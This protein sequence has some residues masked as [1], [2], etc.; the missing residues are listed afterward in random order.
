MR[1]ISQLRQQAP[2][3]LEMMGHYNMVTL[4]IADAFERYLHAHFFFR[5]RHGEWF[6]LDKND[7]EFVCEAGRMGESMV[8]ALAELDDFTEVFGEA[9]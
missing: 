2:Y 1:R 8:H 7:V 9:E 6:E 3:P 5:Q 4:G